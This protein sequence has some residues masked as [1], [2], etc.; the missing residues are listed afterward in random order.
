ME[1]DLEVEYENRVLEAIENIPQFNSR[2]TPPRF[3]LYCV[4]NVLKS[5]GV[6]EDQWL[7]AIPRVV[8]KNVKKHWNN[9]KRMSK[10]KEDAAWK[11]FEDF[12]TEDYECWSMAEAALEFHQLTCGRNIYEFNNKFLEAVDDIKVPR[13]TEWL[14]YEYAFRLPGPVSV[15]VLEKLPETLEE[16]MCH[17]TAYFSLRQV[18]DKH[19]EVIIPR[20]KGRK[21][22]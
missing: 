13:D 3:W 15:D 5:T 17:A 1:Q 20:A 11:D 6:P 12:I 21:R 22:Y 16:A 2:G 14:V 4:N 19:D 18:F 7:M 9:Y 10:L 8:S